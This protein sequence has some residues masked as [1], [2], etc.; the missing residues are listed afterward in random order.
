MVAF[1][2][3]VIFPVVDIFGVVADA[4]DVPA[5]VTE[6]PLVDGLG[7]LVSACVT[8]FSEFEAVAKRLVVG[9]L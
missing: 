4:I 3:V 5:A 2:P 6:G 7:S 8:A 9:V 1:S